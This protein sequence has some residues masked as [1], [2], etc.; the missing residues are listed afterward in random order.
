MP[1]NCAAP[2]FPAANSNSGFDIAARFVDAM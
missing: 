2:D 1:A